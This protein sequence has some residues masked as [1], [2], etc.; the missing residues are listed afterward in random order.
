MANHL[1][2]ERGLKNTVL[3]TNNSGFS[4]AGA[5]HQAYANTLV[6]RW[7]IGDFSSAE[8]T[9]SAD[10]NDTTKELLKCLVTCGQNTAN[11]V[12]YA[13]SNFGTDLL[14]V[15][16][17]VNDSFVDLLVSPTSDAYNGTK[18]LHTGTYFANLNPLMP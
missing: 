15:T 13:R 11:V 4:H 2:F 8:I 7:H 9:I 18:F 10:F 5:W 16:V 14:D 3:M 1:P 17:T 6:E 12:I